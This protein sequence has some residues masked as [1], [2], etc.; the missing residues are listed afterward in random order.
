MSGT[1]IAAIASP[2]IVALIGAYFGYRRVVRES[3]HRRSVEERAANLTELREVNRALHEEID[4][5]RSDSREDRAELRVELDNLSAEVRWLRRD[6]ADQ[7]R[8][9]NAWQEFSTAI[10]RWVE[11][12]MPQAREMG[13]RVTEPPQPPSLQSLVA[14]DVMDPDGENPRRRWSDHSRNLPPTE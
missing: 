11:M 14:A 1:Q 7:I 8:R 2:I 9:D 6:R 5:V 3:D 4:R 10:V 12:W 13:L